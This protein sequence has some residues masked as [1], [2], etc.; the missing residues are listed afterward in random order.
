[1]LLLG[2]LVIGGI[3]AAIAAS[4]IVIYIDGKITEEKI[5]EELKERDVR[6]AIVKRIDECNRVILLKDLLSDQEYEIH[7]D[8]IDDSLITGTEITIETIKTILENTISEAN[9]TIRIEDLLSDQE[10]DINSDG[11]DD[12]IAT[13]EIITIDTQTV[14]TKNTIRIEDLLSDPE[15][16]QNFEFYING[17]VTKQR[18]GAELRRRGAKDVIVISNSHNVITLSD[19]IYDQEYVIYGD[20]ID[21]SLTVGEIIYV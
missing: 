7:G 4:A 8:S 2:R 20:S 14:G 1:M 5:E 6:K 15:Y 9:G 21:S 19:L 17:V 13:E 10:Y 3:I 11:I 18:I 16:D 12:C